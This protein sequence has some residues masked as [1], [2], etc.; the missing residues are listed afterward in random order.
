LP[1]EPTHGATQDDVER[2]VR[3]DFR[4]EQ[5]LDVMSAL[6]EFDNQ[7]ESTRI[8]VRLA[9]L[10]LSDGNLEALKKYITVAKQDFWDVIS[11]AEYC[12]TAAIV[13]N[14]PKPLSKKDRQQIAGA[15][16]QQ[17]EDWLRK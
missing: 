8:R 3:R 5:L 14:L 7:L 13:R 12:G 16:W 4:T 1:P 2:I 17:Y 9:V 6:K 11:L 15:L 10:K